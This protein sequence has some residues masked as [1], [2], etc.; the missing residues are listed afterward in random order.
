MCAREWECAREG[1]VQKRT[2]SVRE[3][4]VP[5]NEEYGMEGVCR[6]RGSVQGENMCE[7]N[8]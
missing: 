2:G 4:G 7:G 1:E 8:K 3:N 5:E 6:G